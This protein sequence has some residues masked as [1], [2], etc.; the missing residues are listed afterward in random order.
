MNILFWIAQI[1]LSVIFTLVGFM[2]VSQPILKLSKNMG[3]VNDFPTLFVRGLG[4]LEIII[5]LLILLPRLIKTLPMSLMTYGGYAIVIIMVGAVG[6][7]IKRGEFS[8]VIMNL[9]ILGLTAFVL[10]KAKSL[11]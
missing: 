7:H 2:K 9:I 10:Y 1:L 4:F 5:G 6:V 11:T 8:T 3:W